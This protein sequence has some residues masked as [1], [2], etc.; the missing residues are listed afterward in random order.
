MFII[1]KRWIPVSA[2]WMTKEGVWM[3]R[4][5]KGIFFMGD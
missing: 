1:K 5:C 2:T 3:T 4:F